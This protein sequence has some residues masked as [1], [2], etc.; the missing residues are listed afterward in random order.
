MLAWIQYLD[1]TQN[2]TTTVE[3]TRRS[4]Y[5]CDTQGVENWNTCLRKDD[6]GSESS[7]LVRDHDTA[8]ATSSPYS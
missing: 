1:V 3:H 8:Y 6:T 2:E 4:T 5:I 7:H